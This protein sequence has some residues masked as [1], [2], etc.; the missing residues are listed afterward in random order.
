MTHQEQLLAYE[1]T[2]NTLME[3][4]TE[5][6]EEQLCFSAQ[7]IGQT[8][9]ILMTIIGMLLILDVLVTMYLNKK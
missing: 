2:I 5:H 1:H 8:A 3:E 4:Q 7:D 6:T 9:F